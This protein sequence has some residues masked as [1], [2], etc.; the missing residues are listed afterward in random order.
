M[1]VLGGVLLLLLF[2]DSFSV[3]VSNVSQISVYWYEWLKKS[4]INRILHVKFV[5]TTVFNIRSSGI[6]SV[7]LKMLAYLQF[8]STDLYSL[9]ESQELPELSLILDSN[10]QLCGG[11][12]WTNMAE[13]CDNNT[14]HRVW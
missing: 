4:N 10:L 11:F 7:F 2:R 12:G 13:R 14:K 6:A 5:Q 8:S 3:I 9:A 1:K